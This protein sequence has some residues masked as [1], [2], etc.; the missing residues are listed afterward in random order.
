MD[1]RLIK[2]FFSQD[3]LLLL[4]ADHDTIFLM[5]QYVKFFNGAIC[6]KQFTES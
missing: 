3:F 6:T 4:E 5:V 2:Q 1:V